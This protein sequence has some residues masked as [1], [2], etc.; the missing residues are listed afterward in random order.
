M[1]EVSVTLI[2][3]PTSF[4]QI[5]EERQIK[6]MLDRENSRECSTKVNNMTE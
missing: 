5:A 2:Q 1:K 3:E 4:D 6:Q